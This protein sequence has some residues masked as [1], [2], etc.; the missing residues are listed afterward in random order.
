M[1]L[2]PILLTILQLFTISLSSD[3]EMRLYNDLLTNYNALERP[4]GN[5]SEPLV[6]KMRLFLQQIVD[7]D[8]K[9]QV[10]QINA[11]LRFVRL[12]FIPFYLFEIILMI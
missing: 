2:S 11:W 5:A 1:R 4:V 6:V 9:N 8:E 10:V 3:D 12:I 7:V